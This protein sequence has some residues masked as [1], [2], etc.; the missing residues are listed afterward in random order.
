MSANELKPRIKA[1]HQKNH[2]PQHYRSLWYY[3]HMNKQEK[4]KMGQDLVDFMLDE[5]SLDEIADTIEL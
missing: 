1:F 5:L 4:Q 2:P 3:Y